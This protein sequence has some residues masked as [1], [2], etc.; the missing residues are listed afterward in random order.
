MTTLL[1]QDFDDIKYTVQKGR[2][3]LDNIF[4]F[5]IG[6]LVFS[7]AAIGVAYYAANANTIGWDTLSEAWHSIFYVEAA[8]FVVHILVILLSFLKSKFIHKFSII[9]MVFF[10]YKMVVDPFVLILM[11][12]KDRGTYDIYLPLVF[13]IISLGFLLHFTLV[14]KMLYEL[15]QEKRERKRTTKNSTIKWAIPI[16][17]L[18]VVLTGI[19]I[20]SGV[21]GDNDLS[22]LLILSTAL[23]LTILIG[24]VEFVLAAYCVI[25]FPSFLDSSSKKVQIQKK[26]K[27]KR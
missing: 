13:Q 25:R 2:L 5:F 11:V 23:L 7:G 1:E 18:L 10:S 19:I 4:I 17:F 14:I 16:I 24:A 21:L 3:A 12:A 15:K 20:D 8:L 9:M 26:K 27:R 22:F 6:V